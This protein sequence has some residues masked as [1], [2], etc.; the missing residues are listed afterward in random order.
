M[1]DETQIMRKKKTK[2][3]TGKTAPKKRKI[4]RKARSRVIKGKLTARDK[5]A[6]ARGFALGRHSR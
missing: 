6:F 5:A 3:I 4:K 2:K 1:K